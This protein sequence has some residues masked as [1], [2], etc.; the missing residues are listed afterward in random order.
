M[1]PKGPLEHVQFGAQKIDLGPNVIAQ[2]LTGDNRERV[3][4][5]TI[6][7][8]RENQRMRALA[9]KPGGHGVARQAR[10]RRS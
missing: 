3:Q 10:D 4:H 7:R 5:I 6:R 9:Q 2:R 1:A 8:I